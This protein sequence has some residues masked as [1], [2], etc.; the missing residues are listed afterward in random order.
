[1]SRILTLSIFPVSKPL[2]RCV[3]SNLIRSAG[4]IFKRTARLYNQDFLKSPVYPWPSMPVSGHTLHAA[5]STSPS[6]A[7]LDVFDSRLIQ[8]A[9]LAVLR[10][11]EEGRS[12]MGKGNESSRRTNTQRAQNLPEKGRNTRRTS[13]REIRLIIRYRFLY[14]RY[15]K[16]NCTGMATLVHT[17]IADEVYTCRIMPILSHV[18]P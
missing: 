12:Q 17:L 2:S 10:G 14:Q 11:S 4:L 5:S 7:L 3:G 16:S 8:F 1:M 15:C 18:S 6:P 9:T 13:D